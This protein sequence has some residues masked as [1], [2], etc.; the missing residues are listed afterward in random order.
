MLPG[1]QLL[2]CTFHAFHALADLDQ[3]QP[4]KN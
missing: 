4:A 2:I 3:S 1:L